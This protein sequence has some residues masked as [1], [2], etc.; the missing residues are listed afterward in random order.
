MR[1]NL[2]IIEN[3]P[4]LSVLFPKGSIIVANKRENNVKDLLL[5]ADPCNI[6]EDLYQNKPMGYSK[7][8]KRNCDS[9]QNYV[10]ETTSI[11]S[12][13]TGRKFTIRRESSCQ[14]KH[15]IYVAYCK[16]CGKQGVGSTICWKLRLSNYKC[17]IKKG[18]PTCRIVR[19]F[20]DECNNEALQNIRFI[21]V[22]VV[23]NVEN[24]TGEEVEGILLAKEKFW[25]G[26]L[27]S[28]HK[29]LNSMHDWNRKNRRDKENVT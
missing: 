26:T 17:H 20:L 6:K 16:V 4:E 5:R 7:C 22:D 9:C 28:Q 15:L 14:T 8:D 19:H 2:S 3:H 13:A 1:K 25:I 10:D 21:I 23:N 11:I 18:K 24:L 29:G 27:V 12:N